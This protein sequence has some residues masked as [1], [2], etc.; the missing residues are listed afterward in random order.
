MTHVGSYASV[1]GIIV[2][3]IAAISGLIVHRTGA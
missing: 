1:A 2:A 3:S